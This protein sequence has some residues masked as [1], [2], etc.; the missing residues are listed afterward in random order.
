[1]KIYVTL[2]G[3]YAIGPGLKSASFDDRIDPTPKY[4]L[5][6]I[7]RDLMLHS[8]YVL[9]RSDDGLLTVIKSRLTLSCNSMFE[10]LSEFNKFREYVYLN[11]GAMVHHTDYVKGSLYRWASIQQLNSFKDYEDAMSIMAVREL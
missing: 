11:A 7:E 3:T 6:K 5:G 9:V 1:M 4:T 10:S 2:L 8:D